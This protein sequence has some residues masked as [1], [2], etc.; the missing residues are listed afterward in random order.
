[1]PGI[2]EFK[3]FATAYLR[4]WI[5]YRFDQIVREVIKKHTGGQP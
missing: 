3:R 5:D 2:E 1:M 4:L